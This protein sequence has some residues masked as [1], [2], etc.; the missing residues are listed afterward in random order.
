MF[1]IKVVIFLFLHFFYFQ[2]CLFAQDN[3]NKKIILS[4]NIAYVFCSANDGQWNWLLDEQGNFV[5]VFGKE[6]TLKID[7]IYDFDNYIQIFLIDDSTKEKLQTYKTNCIKQFGN[8]FKYV[9]P[10]RYK[11]SHWS[12]FSTKQGILAG[13][14]NILKTQSFNIKNPLILNDAEL[15][16]YKDISTVY[17]R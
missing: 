7:K 10:A 15:V 16:R 13:N 3:H 8:N 4:D 12:L 11:I 9:Q 1:L 17:P 6:K 5:Y 14:V 2:S